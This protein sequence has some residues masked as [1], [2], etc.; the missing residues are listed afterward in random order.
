MH[1]SPVHSMSRRDS[2]NASTGSAGLLGVGSLLGVGGGGVDLGGGVLLSSATSGSSAPSLAHPHPAAV[3]A[4]L[5]DDALGSNDYDELM[6]DYEAFRSDRASRR[7]SRRHH[8]EV[9]RAHG[10]HDVA[11]GSADRSSAGQRLVLQEREQEVELRVLWIGRRGEVTGRRE[12][13]IGRGS[14]RTCAPPL[15]FKADCTTVLLLAYPPPMTPTDGV[16]DGCGC[17]PAEE[18]EAAGGAETGEAARTRSLPPPQQLA[19]G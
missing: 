11:P 3:A 15:V 17:D 4:W 13:R 7:D 12:D 9:Q 18:G 8:S 2:L 19:R 14:Q 1:A 16:R 10:R 5:E 6:A